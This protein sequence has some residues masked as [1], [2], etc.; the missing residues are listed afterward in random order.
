MAIFGIPYPNYRRFDRSLPEIAASK[1][2]P[3]LGSLAL[4]FVLAIAGN[5]AASALHLPVPGTLIAALVLVLWLARRPADAARLPAADLLV[6]ALPL[7]F[8]PLIV[9]AVAPLRALGAALLPFAL[10]TAG[11][12]LA[13]L[14]ATVAV[15]RVTAWLSSPSR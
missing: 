2:T 10:T 4:L 5:A 12:T 13:A 7:L 8:V 15:A 14:A 9:E 6:G 1:A 3:F 11:A